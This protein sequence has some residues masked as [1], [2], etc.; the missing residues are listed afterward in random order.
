[1]RMA[2]ALPTSRLGA[3][4]LH[5]AAQAAGFAMACPYE[6]SLDAHAADVSTWRRTRQV[7]RWRLIPSRITF[8][9]AAVLVIL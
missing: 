4:A 9:L 1:M 3:L 8:L 6:T 5:D 7:E 2:H